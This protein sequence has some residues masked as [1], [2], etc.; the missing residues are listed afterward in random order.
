MMTE[1]CADLFPHLELK[2]K[3]LLFWIALIPSHFAKL[4][5]FISSMNGYYYIEQTFLVN[6]RSSKTEDP[7]GQRSGFIL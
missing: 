7:C 3:N 4:N 2:H 1:L 5:P 6:K